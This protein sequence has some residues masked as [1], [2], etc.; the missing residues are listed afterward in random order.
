MEFTHERLRAK[1]EGK[2]GKVKA[3][4]VNQ[5]KHQAYH[6]L[7]M[8][9]ARARPSPCLGRVGGK[10]KVIRRKNQRIWGMMR[11]TQRKERMEGF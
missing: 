2:K 1:E 7:L 3:K 9:L 10:K 6:G 4:Y 5:V 8:K 11:K